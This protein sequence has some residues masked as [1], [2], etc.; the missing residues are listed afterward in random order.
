MLK[1]TPPP[2]TKFCNCLKKDDFPMSG[3]S[4][5]EN[6]LYYSKISCVDEKNK[7]KLYKRVRET[8]FKKRCANHK[9]SFNAT[10]KQER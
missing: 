6:V 3:D 9:K 2:K 1:N 5:T 4:L 10:K 7:P 8:T